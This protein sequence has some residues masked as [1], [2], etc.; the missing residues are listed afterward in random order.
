LASLNSSSSPDRFVSLVK[1]SPPRHPATSLTELYPPKKESSQGHCYEQNGC[2]SHAGREFLCE[3][4]TENAAKAGLLRASNEDC[5]SSLCV[6]VSWYEQR[7]LN[8]C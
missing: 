1:K 6:L 2:Q 5:R 7:S 8:A 3:I 4:V